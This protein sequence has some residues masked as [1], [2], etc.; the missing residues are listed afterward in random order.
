MEGS[1]EPGIPSPVLQSFSHLDEATLLLF[2]SCHCRLVEIY[3][4]LFQAIQRCIK[5]PHTTSHSPAG[6]ILPQ[7]QWAAITSGYSYYVS[8]AHYNDVVATMGP[9]KRK[10][11]KGKRLQRTEEPSARKPSWGNGPG[12][13]YRG[14]ED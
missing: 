1:Y 10:H 9:S 3:E 8:H 13:G 2:L 6:I 12:M 14:Q 7:L 4:S 5:G 11:E